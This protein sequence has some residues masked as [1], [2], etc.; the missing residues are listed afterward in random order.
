M[1]NYK[2]ILTCVDF[3]DPSDRAAE[4]A[5]SLAEN[6]DAKITLLHIVNY[7]PPVYMGVELPASVA[8]GELLEK[9]ARKHMTEW[10]ESMGLSHCDQVVV[11]GQA[12]NAIVN[13][14]AD[15]DIDLVVLGAHGETGLTRL[16]GSVAN[17][18][19]QHVECDSLIVR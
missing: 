10:A 7:T 12:R 3:S 14:C 13:A 11:S 19:T 16:F 2:H 8:S 5:K 1:D 6:Y 15:K 4:R 18:V 17:Y 9:G